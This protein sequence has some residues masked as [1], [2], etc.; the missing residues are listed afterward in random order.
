MS[1]LV[2]F[3]NNYD[4]AD[5]SNF[6]IVNA[7]N[8][9]KIKDNCDLLGHSVTERNNELSQ[10]SFYNRQLKN[11]VSRIPCGNGVAKDIVNSFEPSA[12]L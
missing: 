6:N 5:G 12:K 10:K 8:D 4:G 11:R 1:V 9:V 3:D 2:V 7:S